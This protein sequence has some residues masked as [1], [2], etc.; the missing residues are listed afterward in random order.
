MQTVS[1]TIEVQIILLENARKPNTLIKVKV[2]TGIIKTRA[3]SIL[4]KSSKGGLISPLL[5]S[6][7]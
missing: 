7:L 2:S 4:F 1:S 5:P 6:F 3:R